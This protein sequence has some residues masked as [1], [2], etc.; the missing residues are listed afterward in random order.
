M[1]IPRIFS[2][3]STLLVKSR[4]ILKGANAP[5]NFWC[6]TALPVS[7]ERVVYQLDRAR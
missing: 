3:S 4:A 2:H 7:A 6:I 1:V 5:F